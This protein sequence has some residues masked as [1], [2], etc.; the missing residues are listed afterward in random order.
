[1]LVGDDGGLDDDVL[2]LHA[3]VLH[4]DLLHVVC[5]GVGEIDVALHGTGT[6]VGAAGEVEDVVGIFLSIFNTLFLIFISFG[7]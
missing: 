1:M 4:E 7:I 2:L 5:T 3:E 6:L